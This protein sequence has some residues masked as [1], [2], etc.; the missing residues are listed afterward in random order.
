MDFVDNQ[1]DPQSGT[2][3]GRAVIPNPDF[4]LSAGQFVRLRLPGSGTYEAVLIPD[5]AIGTDQAQRFVWVIDDEN[6]AQYRK[7]TVGP[8]YEG[9]RI[10]RDGLGAEDRVV[11][12]GLQRVRPGIVVAPEEAPIPPCPAAAPIP[13]PGPPAG[14]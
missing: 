4:M 3:L 7:I 11:T 13:S 8:L 6:V 10:V 5:P 14:E 2:I 9:L 1:L 12:S